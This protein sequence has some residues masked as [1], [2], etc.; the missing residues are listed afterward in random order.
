[1]P[2]GDIFVVG[3]FNRSVK[4]NELE[5]LSDCLRVNKKFAVISQERMEIARFGS[6]LALVHDR[7]L[8]AMGGF[9]TPN[10]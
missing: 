7:F 1:M 3:G 9:T 6:P 5:V 8:L 4:S 10:D 2:N